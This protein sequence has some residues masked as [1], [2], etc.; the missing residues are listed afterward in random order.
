MGPFHVGGVARRVGP[1]SHALDIERIKANLGAVHV[2]AMLTDGV[3]VDVDPAGAGVEHIHKRR[4]GLVGASADT[5]VG[6]LDG[7]AQC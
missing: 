5:R 2:L 4:R 7:V 3:I 6:G 1:E